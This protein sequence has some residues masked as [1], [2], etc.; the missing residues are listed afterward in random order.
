MNFTYD[1][2]SNAAYLQLIEVEDDAGIVAETLPL[3][4]NIIVDY[5][6]DGRIF[7]IE[8]LN[9][10][11]HLPDAILSESSEKRKKSA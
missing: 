7:G 6:S 5:D 3:T 10:S 11:T 8:F 1:K 9:A 4:E 2:S